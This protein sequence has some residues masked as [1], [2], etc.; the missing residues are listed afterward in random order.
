MNKVLAAVAGLALSSAAAFGQDTAKVEPID[1][2]THPLRDTVL[3]QLVGR[4]EVNRTMAGK[5]SGSMV[6]AQWTLN[7]QFVQLHYVPERGSAQPYEAMVY[8]GYDNMSERYVVHWLDIFG[9][10]ISET[11]GFGKRTPN[12]MQFTF[13]YPDGPF[14]NTFRYD[15]ETRSWNLLLR[16]KNARGEW[17]TFATEQWRRQQ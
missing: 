4:W 8:I 11:L 15:R 13:E 2:I 5:S 16:Q 1:G 10:R 3:E 17:T 6:D 14:T 12:G 9:G 7:H